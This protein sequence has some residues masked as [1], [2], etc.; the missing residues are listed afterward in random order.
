LDYFGQHVISTQQVHT[1]CRE[2][3][4]IEPVARPSAVI[5]SCPYIFIRQAKVWQLQVGK[6]EAQDE[7]T[8]Y[9]N[10]KGILISGYGSLDDTH[11]VLGN[12]NSFF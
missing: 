6:Q 5:H 1:K 2:R 11:V 12:K 4:V 10:Q 9:I 8:S 3:A 7:L